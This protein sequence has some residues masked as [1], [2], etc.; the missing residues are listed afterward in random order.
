MNI[1]TRSGYSNFLSC[2]NLLDERFLLAISFDAISFENFLISSCISWSFWNR[3]AASILSLSSII[4]SSSKIPSKKLLLI[5]V[6][7]G[8]TIASVI[9]IAFSIFSHKNFLATTLRTFKP[10]KNYLR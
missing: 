7:F 3:K 8:V 10:S 5:S 6:V 2:Q 1:V 4:K 9:F